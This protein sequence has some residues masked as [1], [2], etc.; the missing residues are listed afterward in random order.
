MWEV[1][2]S[3][4]EG[5]GII[6]SQDIKKG[7]TIGHAYDLIGE[8]NGKYIA[9]DISTLGS[10]HNHNPTPNAKPEIYINKIYFEAVKDIKQGT[11]ITCNYNEYSDVLNIEKPLKEWQESN[12]EN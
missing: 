11:E 6:A 2:E 3:T 8:V 9:G 10:V 12:Y 5:Q 1:G 7:V 4:I